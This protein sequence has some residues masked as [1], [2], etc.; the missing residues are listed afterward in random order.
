MYCMSCGAAVPEKAAFCYAC[1]EAVTVGKEPKKAH[2]YSMSC[3]ACGSSYLKKA[4]RR[5][6]MRTLWYRVTHG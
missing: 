3:S 4:L 1:G 2:L 6:P 5:I